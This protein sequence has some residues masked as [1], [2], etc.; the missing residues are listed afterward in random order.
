ML[1]FWLALLA[2]HAPSVMK[3]FFTSCIW[4]FPLRTLVRG[5]RPMRAVPISWMQRPGALQHLGAGHLDVLEDVPLVVAPGALD[6]ER[7]DPPFV[8]ERRVDRREVVA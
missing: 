7:G 3:T 8:L 1:G 6:L 4:L 2:M 5:S